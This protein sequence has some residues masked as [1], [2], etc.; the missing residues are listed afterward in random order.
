MQE[1]EH[2]MSPIT[3]RG[4]TYK[5]RIIAAPTGYGHFMLGPRADASYRMIEERAMGGQAAVCVGESSINNGDAKRAGESFD[6]STTENNDFQVLKKAADMI[7]K[8]GAI[9]MIELFH[10]G[11]AGDPNDEYPNPWGPVE[12][13][14]EDGVKVIAY[15]EEM[16]EK[17]REDF[18]HA[19]LYMKKAGY[20]G[21]LIHGGHG[22]LFTQFL[23][24]AENTRTDQYGG[25][26]LVNRMRFPLEILRRIRERV[27]EDFIIELRISGS[28]RTKGGPTAEE[29]AE[30]STKL[31]GLVDIL[32]ISSGHYYKSYRT[33]EFSS[34]FS[35]HGCNVD[36]ATIIR[37]KCPKD[38]LLGVIGGINSPEMGEQLIADGIVD[39]I[40]LGRQMFADPNFSKKIAEGHAGD[41][42]RCLRCNRCYAG[43]IEHPIEIEYVKKHPYQRSFPNKERAY[44]SVNPAEGG[45]AYVCDEYPLPEASRNVP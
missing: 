23:S 8:H 20:D 24:A 7:H 31:S 16:M 39:F 45:L 33:L 12:F 21:V 15:N 44:C 26:N 13:T 3:V 2:L 14:R 27:G 37:K 6:F 11:S 32:H 9:A 35:K 22:W 38:V 40:I 36:S 34:H 43:S 30:F 28:E 41:I 4:K 18:A 25:Q 42:Q 10:P 29:S 19:A 5:N 1:F 17:T